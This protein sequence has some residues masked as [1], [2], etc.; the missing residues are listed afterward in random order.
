[1]YVQSFAEFISIIGLLFVGVFITI[2]CIEIGLCTF[3][4]KKNI[5]VLKEL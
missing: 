3:L 1:M 5:A 4:I 2:I